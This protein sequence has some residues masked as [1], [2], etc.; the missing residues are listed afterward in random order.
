LVEN[1][2]RFVGIALDRLMADLGVRL[3]AQIPKVFRDSL[4]AN[5]RLG[6][7]QFLERLSLAKSWRGDAN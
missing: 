3:A 6:C 1:S 7:E 4:A 2:I 5:L